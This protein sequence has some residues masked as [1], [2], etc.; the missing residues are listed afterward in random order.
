MYT[1]K[2]KNEIGKEKSKCWQFILVEGGLAI[3]IFR[4][5]GGWKKVPEVDSEHKILGNSKFRGKCRT[6]HVSGSNYIF[7][8]CFVQSDNTTASLHTNSS[9]I[10]ICHPDALLVFKWPLLLIN[11]DNILLPLFLTNCPTSHPF[12]LWPWPICVI[13]HFAAAYACYCDG[14]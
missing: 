6:A 9:R 3:I 1:G 13:S 12:T 11:Y 14:A 5:A 4:R 2:E 10:F 8:G 7:S